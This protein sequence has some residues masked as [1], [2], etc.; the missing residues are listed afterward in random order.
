MC[1]KVIGKKLKLIEK[2]DGYTSQDYNVE[3]GKR[4]KVI[5]IDG[6]CYRVETPDGIATINAG[7][8]KK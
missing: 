6:C 3:V 2:P 1:V 7:R 5:G 8:F 4:Y